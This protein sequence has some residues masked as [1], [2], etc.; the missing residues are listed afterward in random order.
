MIPKM[1]VKMF[2]TFVDLKKLY[3]LVSLEKPVICPNVSSLIV[4]IG[5]ISTI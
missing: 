5:N 4:H 2:L 3:H 1:S